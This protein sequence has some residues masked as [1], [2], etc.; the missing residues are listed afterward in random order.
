[1]VL[2]EEVVSVAEE[3]VR[4]RSLKRV[5][6]ALDFFDA[7]MNRIG[8]WVIGARAMLKA[9]LIALMEP[10]ELLQDFEEK[11][12][13]FG[14]LALIEEFKAMPFG[15]VWDYYC[16]KRGVPLGDACIKE[17]HK[18]EQEVTRPRSF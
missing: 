16:I 18:Y 3:I 8:A 13:F 15:A 10:R 17:I 1:V 6:M 11:G 9:L 12:D 7:T 5:Y 4:S 14:R 2:N